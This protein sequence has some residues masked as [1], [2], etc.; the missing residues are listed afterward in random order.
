MRAAELPGAR[1]LPYE[2]FEPDYLRDLIERHLAPLTDRYF[3]PRRGG[4]RDR[5][6]PCG[7]RGLGRRQR[8]EREGVFVW[9]LNERPLPAAAPG[10]RD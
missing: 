2:P 5:K 10:D 6:P 4:G 9:K 8:R 3:R 7:Y 1:G